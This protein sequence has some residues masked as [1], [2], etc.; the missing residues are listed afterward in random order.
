MNIS[1]SNQ[2]IYIIG[3]VAILKYCLDLIGWIYLHFIASNDMKKYMKPK[4]LWGKKNDQKHYFIYDTLFIN[5]V[6]CWALVTGGSDGIGMGFAKELALKGMNVIISARGEDTLK[7]VSHFLFLF[8][9]IIYS[10]M[11]VI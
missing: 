5:L 6:D 1:Y 2:A 9:I 8:H 3:I 4:G 10:S 7:E 11:F